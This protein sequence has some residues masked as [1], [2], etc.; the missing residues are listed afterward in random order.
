MY[1]IVFLI[2]GFGGIPISICILITFLKYRELPF[3]KIPFLILTG[4][5]CLMAIYGIFGVIIFLY[6]GRSGEPGFLFWVATVTY[7]VETI[8][9]GLMIRGSEKAKA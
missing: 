2:S 6:R 9:S 7:I 8:L 1:K 3:M 4:L 5:Y